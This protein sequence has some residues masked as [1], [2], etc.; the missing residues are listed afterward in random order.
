[1]SHL[2]VDKI[3]TKAKLY[4]KKGEINEAKS[5]CKTFLNTYP[6]NLRVKQFLTS[7][8][9]VKSLTEIYKTLSD[10]Y[11]KSKYKEVIE[12][13]QEY[14]E[15]YP[16]NVS[17]LNFFGIGN[18][19][20]G[21]DLVAL[22]TFRKVS[23]INP[24]F[25][26]GINNLG[27]TL[28]KIGELDEAIN[29]Y[30]KVIS[31]N[32]SFYLAYNNIGNILR[33]KGD[34]TKAIDMFYK[35]ISIEPNYVDAHSNLAIILN[36]RGK[37]N[38]AIKAF[39]KVLS[40]KPGCSGTLNCLGNIYK[41]QE[42]FDNAIEMY[43]KAISIDPDFE[44]ARAQR[45]F[46]LSCICDWKSIEQEKPFIENLG[47]NKNFI[48]TF[49]LLSLED[50]PT[51][52]R[53]R[54]ETFAKSVFLYNPIPFK[55][56][57]SKDKKKIRLGYFSADFHD[58]ATMHLMSKVFLLHD[59]ES[60]EIY[61]Y[62][63]G[64]QKNDYMRQNLIKAV[65]VFDDV[66]QM[67]DRDIAL[68]ARQDEIDI[69]I[70]LKGYT[71]KSRPGVFAFRAAPIQVNYLGYPGTMGAEF[72]DYIIADPIL[73]PHEFR[74]SYSENI[75]YMPNSYQPNNNDRQISDMQMSKKEMG[76]P[77]NSFVFCS[78]NNT[79]KISKVEFEIWMRLLKKVEGSVL[80]L[81]KSNQWSETNLKKEAENFGINSSR[82]IFAH[83]VNTAEH[84]ARHKFADLFLDTFNVNA[85]TT[86]SD[87]LWAGLP[88]VTKLGK[89][90]VARVAASLLNSVGLQELIT[91]NNK[92]YEDLIFDLAS[93][94]Q[95]LKKIR[96]K[97]I[98]NRNICPLFNTE[99]YTKDLEKSYKTIYHNYIN[100]Q[101]FKDIYI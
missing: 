7:L 30:N 94:P 98:L 54:A 55:K 100:G 67:S 37:T 41:D 24:K 69:A 12:Q 45:L 75:I 82:L 44:M 77:E 76:L 43:N 19:A 6:K 81:L 35:A 66:S 31:I 10:L 18:L 50:N 95:R 71:H 86:A 34:F 49:S 62:S 70:D 11:Y 1:M 84:L 63:F 29:V 80:W 53:K 42:K 79:Y 99:V 26:D 15:F 96:D 9:E 101:S 72:M 83:R 78:F 27:V 20:L 52:Q 57:P 61:A 74:S 13:S 87:A 46:M 17:I 47:K 16:D 90:F 36:D 33:K 85:H 39:K 60:F 91:E 73:I 58:H 56:L 92:D 5:F 3:L 23:I 51:N 32:S 97:L 65:D 28:E 48:P 38:E 68:L 14:L 89:S 25:A 21:N 8:E 4:A 88:V 64:P 40:L 59:Q 2:S 22:E 93:K